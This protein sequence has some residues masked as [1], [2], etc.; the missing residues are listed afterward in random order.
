[1][2]KKL[3]LAIVIAAAWL[4]ISA[5]ALTSASI[6]G[7]CPNE[8]QELIST[9]FRSTSLDSGSM[10]E[11]F[12]ELNN[13]TSVAKLEI[14]KDNWDGYWDNRSKATGLF[15]GYPGKMDGAAAKL[16]VCIAQQRIVELKGNSSS[17]PTPLAAPYTPA[18]LSTAEPRA[19]TKQVNSAKPVNRDTW[20]AIAI[21]T[22]HGNQNGLAIDHP[23][24]ASADKAAEEDCQRHGSRNE[25]TAVAHFTNGCAAYAECTTAIGDDC[26]WGGD[27][28]ATQAQAEAGAIRECQKLESGKFKCE[29]RAS[30][31]NS[32]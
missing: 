28:G 18:P 7:L 14:Y 29:I 9:G 6:P 19:S 10:G 1:M 13:E 5:F 23:S 25:C 16:A 30:A 12:L 21:D 31:C 22:V 11:A 15:S 32:R 3:A 27:V 20:G 17:K 24:Q 2:S 8:W 4:P 26:A